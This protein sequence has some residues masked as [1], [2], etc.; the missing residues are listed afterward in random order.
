MGQW[1]SWALF[2]SSSLT[3]VS[4]QSLISGHHTA[5]GRVPLEATE[6]LVAALNSQWC[7]WLGCW[8][9]QL[10]ATLLSSACYWGQIQWS[11]R[12]LCSPTL[13]RQLLDNASGITC[14]LP[15]SST[16]WI[17]WG[18]FFFS[19]LFNGEAEFEIRYISQLLFFLASTTHSQQ[20]RNTVTWHCI[21]YSM[22]MW[23]C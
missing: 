8:V 7:F 14:F 5:K 12:Y 11:H 23:S 10:S 18:R 1:G 20:V 2:I 9:S 22:A 4:S 15:S 13:D 16:I 19:F 21:K 6:S 3:R 17:F